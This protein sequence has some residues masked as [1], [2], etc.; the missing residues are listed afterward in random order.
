[1]RYRGAVRLTAVISL[2]GLLGAACGSDKPSSG[3]TTTTAGGGG[4]GLKVDVTKCTAPKGAAVKL[5]LQWVTQAQFAGYYAAVD[6]NFFKDA[7]LDVTIVE[8]GV[9]IPPQKTLASGA[10]DF[11]ISW[12]PKALAEREAGA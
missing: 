11:A 2:A 7:G 8:G 12:V 3:A 4:S 1:M 6:Q 10:V 5:Q 9:D